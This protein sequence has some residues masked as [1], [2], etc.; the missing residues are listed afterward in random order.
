LFRRLQE[1]SRLVEAIKLGI[2]ASSGTERRDRNSRVGG[3]LGPVE[4]PRVRL[5]TF[6][7]KTAVTDIG[8]GGIRL[9]FSKNNGI[10]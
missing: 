10:I 4:N 6:D 5:R 2:I 3:R 7:T 9:V 8:F 1:L